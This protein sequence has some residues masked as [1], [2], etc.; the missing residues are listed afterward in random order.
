MRPLL[1]R[2]SNLAR[3]STLSLSERGTTRP[4]L[5]SSVIRLVSFPMAAPY[6]KS[7]KFRGTFVENSSKR[8]LV[9]QMF[10]QTSSNKGALYSYTEAPA[11]RERTKK[12]RRGG[13]HSG[14]M[15]PNRWASAIPWFN[16]STVEPQAAFAPVL[17]LDH[18]PV[19]VGLFGAVALHR[20]AWL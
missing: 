7:S 18:S 20:L 10:L 13:D 16:R 4:T 1:R 17:A 6:A 12:S 2:G 15:E 11:L 9:R 14:Q 19:I 5:I 3:Y 8:A